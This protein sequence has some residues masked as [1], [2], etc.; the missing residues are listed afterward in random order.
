MQSNIFPITEEQRFD[1]V[2]I[3]G[4]PSGSQCGLWLK[5]LGYNPVILE[6]SG[7]LGG[8]QNQNPYENH[9]I[10]CVP[11]QTGGRIAEA[12]SENIIRHG[13]AHITSVENLK[14]EKD[15]SKQFVVSCDTPFG[16]YL[17]SSPKI[18]IASGV[19]HKAGGF[20]PSPAVVIGSGFVI[21]NYD[22]SDKKVAI[23]GGGDTA[24]ENYFFIKDKAAK[25]V[26]IFARTLRARPQLTDKIPPEDIIT[27]AFEANQQIMQVNNEKFDVFCVM[28]GWQAAIPL[29]DK[30]CPTLTSNGFIDTDNN[31]RTSD[32]NIFAIGECTQRTHPCVTTAMAD[33]VIAAKAIQQDLEKLL[34]RVA[35]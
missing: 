11:G 33:G 30:L 17:L 34:N 10:V 18:V 15:G 32:V 14:T 22:F 13:V 4:G 5:M 3:G 26:K 24:A 23:L 1:A 25:E 19:G 16:S 12:I 29:P 7:S 6:K 35:P 27:G 28:F 9:W 2:I 31:C 8:L 20:V 21:Q